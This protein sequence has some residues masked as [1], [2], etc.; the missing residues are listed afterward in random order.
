MPFWLWISWEALN[1][2]IFWILHICSFTKNEF[3]LVAMKPNCM[4]TI[5][6]TDFSESRIQTELST[7]SHTCL[8][9][10]ELYNFEFC[11]FRA[12]IKIFK[13][14]NSLRYRRFLPMINLT[15]SNSWSSHSHCHLIMNN[16][17]I[18]SRNQIELAITHQHSNHCT[19]WI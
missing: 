11:V 8:N 1:P 19:C 16:I 10:I 17:S 13:L 12:T 4:L 3:R 14:E 6:R 9:A 18:E 7:R 5:A 2:L 15:L